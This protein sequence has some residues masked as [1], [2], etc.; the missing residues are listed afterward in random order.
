MAG[1]ILLTLWTSANSIAVQPTT[2]K[3][4][5]SAESGIRALIADGYAR[6]PTFKKLVD[7]VDD[8]ACVVYVSSIARLSQGMRGALLHWTA[9]NPEMP[10]LRVLLKANLARDEAIAVTGHELQHVIEAVRKDRVTDRFDVTATF[11][12]LDPSSQRGSVHKYDTDEAIRI[13][14]TV[15]DELNQAR[16]DTR[17]R[18]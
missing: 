10:V 11:D 5:R 17:P 7:A 18:N 1:W 4:V 14:V 2:F 13:T 9:A 3:H 15:L 8:L 12:R 16:R 6:S